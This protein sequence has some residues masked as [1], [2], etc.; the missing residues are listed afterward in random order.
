MQQLTHITI[1]SMYKILSYIKFKAFTVNL[2]ST[3]FWTL[4]ILRQNL[5]CSLTSEPPLHKIW[6]ALVSEH[7]ACEWP[8]LMFPASFNLTS[9]I[10][11]HHVYKDMLIAAINEE[12]SCERKLGDHKDPYVITL[13]THPLLYFMHL[14]F[15]FNVMAIF[16]KTKEVF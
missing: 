8:R 7:N 14:Y 3:K 2:S 15:L 11:G 12:V 6:L 9:C 13:K 4:K 1:Y 5:C 10:Q 16:V